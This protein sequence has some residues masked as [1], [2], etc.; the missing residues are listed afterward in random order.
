ML[1]TSRH[2]IPVS[3]IKHQIDAMFYNKMSI[4]HWHI[5][6]DDSFP[7]TIVSEPEFSQAGKLGGSYSPSEIKSVI[8]YA[9]IRGV[10]VVPEI[11]TPAHT[12]SWGR[13]PKYNG[14]V[15]NCSN[16][17][18]GQLDPTLPITYTLLNN[19]MK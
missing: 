12:Q 8:N 7:M 18:T 19:V 11:N 13:A 4:L 9:K 16:M 15:V 14:A 2:F 1:D 10:R 6:D 5:S 3:Q 17:W